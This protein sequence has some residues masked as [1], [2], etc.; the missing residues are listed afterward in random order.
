MPTRVGVRASF[1]LPYRPKSTE[2]SELT[3]AATRPTA[4]IRAGEFRAT[5]RIRGPRKYLGMSDQ[6]TGAALRAV[7]VRRGLRQDDVA[8]RAAISRATVSRVERGHVDRVSLAVLRRI[9]S[10]LDVRVDVVA[11]WQGGELDR[12]LNAGHSALHEAVARWFAALPDWILVPEKSFGI[13]G[14]RGVVDV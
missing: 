11:R 2:D 5:W 3:R 8:T 6:R 4:P 7:R 14:E 12:L 9:G 1:S 13:F 10:V